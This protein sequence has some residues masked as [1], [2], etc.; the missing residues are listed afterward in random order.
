[1]IAISKSAP[2]VKILRTPPD[3][4]TEFL[5][6]WDAFAA[7]EGAKNAFFKKV[8]DSQRAYASLVVPAKRMMFPPY[9]FQADHYYPVKQSR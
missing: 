3:I 1:M 5:K 8:H 7:E 2:S 9:S 4:L 6:T